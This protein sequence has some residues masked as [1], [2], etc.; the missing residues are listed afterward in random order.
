MI[1]GVEDPGESLFC[2][3]AR[4]VDGFAANE[5]WV[6]MIPS[7]DVTP[8]VSGVVRAE[9][10]RGNSRITEFSETRTIITVG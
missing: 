1:L 4:V 8:D 9:W 2:C 10:A 7:L 5:R 3:D 6:W